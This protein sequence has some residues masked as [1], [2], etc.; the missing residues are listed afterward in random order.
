MMHYSGYEKKGIMSKCILLSRDMGVF[1]NKPSWQ[2]GGT[3]L[4]GNHFLLLPGENQ[5]GGCNSEDGQ[6]G[7][8][9]YLF[10]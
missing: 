8:V 3:L 6:A 4:T 9:H 5:H 7:H 10:I 1:S 2:V